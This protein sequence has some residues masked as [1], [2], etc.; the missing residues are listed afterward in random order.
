M[1]G[2]YGKYLDVDLTNRT[3]GEY[4]IPEDWYEKH[5]G[6][7]GIAARILLKE[8]PKKINPL[9]E[10]NILVFGTGPL[11]GLGIAG[12]SRFVVMS[13]S[14]KTHTLNDSYSGGSFG[15]HL[16]KTGY[17]GIIIRGKADSPV[18]LLVKDGKVEILPADNIWG[19]DCLEA[20]QDLMEK[21]GKLTVASIGKAGENQVMMSAIMVDH[22][23]AIG[24]P[25]Y[26]MLM[27][28]KNLKAVA[29]WGHLN[30]P[31]ADEKKFRELRGEFVKR[32]M[33]HDWAK[34]IKEFGTGGGVS[35]LSEGGML[36][37]KN[38]T[39]G[40]FVKHADISGRR[41]NEN[42]ILVG[43]D[44]CIGCPVN[45][46]REVQTSFNGQDVLPTWGGPEYETYGA[47]GS[48]CLNSDLTSICLLNQ[49]CNQYGVDTISFGVAAAY[50][51][52]ATEKGLL[53][54]EDAISW[55]DAV[56]MDE[57]LEKIVHRRGIGEWVA[58]GLDYLSLMVG[59]SSFMVHCKG[60]EVPAHDPRI[61]K[62]MAL[63]YTISPRGANHMEGTLDSPAPNEDIGVGFNDIDT[64]EDRAFIAGSYLNLR[65]FGNSLIICSFVTDLNGPGNEF[66]LIRDMLKAITGKEMS[67]EEMMLIGER[68][69]GLLRLHAEQEGFTRSDDDLPRRLKTPLADSG[70]YID[71][72]DLDKAV[73]DFYRLY[74][75]DP[76]GPSNQRL[77]ELG[78]TGLLR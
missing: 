44:T 61:R 59:D 39:S 74:K 21:H 45:C 6:G 12:G 42:G 4:P 25:G 36:P 33:T 41:T 76:Y 57:L 65:S 40:Q 15:H 19:K 51:M 68:N 30:K 22:N 35:F 37:T 9:S 66:P 24:R 78:L 18:Y 49:K 55:G 34:N 26:G 67:A 70:K 10:Q 46:K 50:L 7:R 1:L 72:E 11:Q 54:D 14:P 32:V 77:K 56:A 31:I 17:D 3:T 5:L 8:L 63:Y 64:W 75:Y 60:Q 38:F 23:R 27:G 69:F 2:T 28:I 20:E 58:R 71:D 16:G 47:L 62:S 13:K 73:D 53:R 43:S 52:E 48:F 29:I